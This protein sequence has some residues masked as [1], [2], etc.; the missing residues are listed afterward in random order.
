MLLALLC[1][2][3][4]TAADEAKEQPQINPFPRAT[5]AVEEAHEWDFADGPAGWQALHECRIAHADGALRATASGD[6]PY[7][8]GPAVSVRPGNGGLLLRLRLRGRGSGPVQ[9]Y[10]A[11]EAGGYSPDR[12][13]VIPTEH[14]GE[15]RTVE[16]VLDVTG[17]LR[18]L[19][20]DPGTGPGRV[21]FARATLLRLELHPLEITRL[22]AAPRQITLTVTNH[23]DGPRKATVGDETRTIRAGGSASFGRAIHAGGPFPTAAVTVRS[24][25]LPPLTR[26]AHLFDPAA[27]GEFLDLPAGGLTLRLAADASG[28]LLVRGRAT[29]A[30]L[31]P[32]LGGQS[33]PLTARRDGERIV[34]RGRGATLALAAGKGGT[35]AAELDADAPVAGPA[36]RAIG[37]LEQGVFCG[38]EYLGA[39]EHSSSTADIAPPANVRYAPEPRD[40]TWPLMAVRTPRANVAMAWADPNNRAVF[41]APNFFDG[42]ADHRMAVRGRRLRLTLWADASGPITGT[43]LRAVG[44]LG[45]PEVPAPPRTPEQQRELCLAA[46]RGPVAGEG[47]WGHCAEE[48]WP[49]RPYADIAS[50]IF[51]LTGAAPETDALVP[52]GAHVRDDLAWF[53]TGRAEQW[54]AHRRGA[55][56]RILAE[57]RPDGTF[58]YEG[59]FRRGHFEDTASGHCAKKAWDLLEFARCTGD[60][61]ALA[62]G[63][64]ALDA[65]TR[66]RTPRGAQ[67]WEL[68]LHTP[69]IL[70]SAYLVAAYVRGYEL[71]GKE[72]YLRQ[73]R[74]WALSGLPFVYLRA[75]RPIMLYATTPVFGA[76]KWKAPNWI[77]LPV[78]WCGGVYAYWLTKLAAHDDTLDWAKLARGILVAAEQMQYPAGRLAGCL[79]DIFDLAPQRRAGPSINPAAILS[80]RRAVEGRPTGLCVAA[81][82]GRRVCSPFP[83]AIR[84]GAAR[85]RGREGL[86]YQVLIDGERVVTVRSRGEDVLPLTP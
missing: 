74:R 84:D 45:L 34:V 25:D 5:L 59:E 24:P 72:A 17:E 69:D 56:R 16:A 73:G 4:V 64:R 3:S 33:G 9:V 50:A 66:F 42:T 7:M 38:I 39:G 36:L 51:R 58:A 60:A 28:A 63:L 76:T 23:G 21:D 67:T 1:V 61:K 62:G 19:R 20:L 31:C 54:L 78:Q 18:R 85:I 83:A 32:L 41:A 10:Y 35:I 15:W 86:A 47:G 43:L 13:A 57:Q 70:A 46:F 82:G 37:R 30:V 48:R 53:V 80:L 75:D 44:R 79:P 65:M 12:L 68:S 2:A 8:H 14:D 77:G 71:T 11:D 26:T 55:V 27:G 22:A 6:D 52:G 81:G 49:R 40:V 29:V